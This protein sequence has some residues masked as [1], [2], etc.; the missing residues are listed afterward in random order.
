MIKKAYMQLWTK[1]IMNNNLN[2]KN[3]FI[4]FI[5]LGS[6]FVLSS[7][8][9]YLHAKSNPELAKE[10]VDMLSAELSFIKEFNPLFIFLFIFL[11]NSIKA[12]IATAAGFFFGIFPIFFILFNGY[13]IGLV[14]YIGG[15]EMGIHR[16]LMYIIPHGILEVPAIILAC[17]YGLWLGIQFYKRVVGMKISMKESFLKATD[18]CLRTVVPILLVAAAVETFVTPFVA[19]I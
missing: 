5:L 1:W 8:G 11:N 14:V 2:N 6:L 13:I 18:K 15:T 4:Y 19:G 10:S 16:V 3:I 12:L 17:S 9:G 7:T